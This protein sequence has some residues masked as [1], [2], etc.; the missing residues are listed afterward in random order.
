MIGEK[1]YLDF[2]TDPGLREKRLV[3]V[4]VSGGCDLEKL[5]GT[6]EMEA[7]ELLSMNG[8]FKHGIVPKEK[9]LYTLTIPEEKMIPF[10]L[11]YE[12]KE[13]KKQFRPHLVSY[14]V[15]MGDTLESIAEKYRSSVEEIKTANKLET[16]FLTLDSILLVP[17]KRETF[18]AV[19]R[20][21]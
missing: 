14:V 15:R 1:E 11:K 9:A 3:Q 19:M 7:L 18:E 4:Q 16:D 10:Y 13:E 12:L 5:A 17:V 8:Q 2:P 6:L 21:L 20:A